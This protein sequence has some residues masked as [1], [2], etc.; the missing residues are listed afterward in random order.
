[1][2]S[3]CVACGVFQVLS[4]TR[5]LMQGLSFLHAAGLVHA[6]LKPDNIVISADARTQIGRA[7][8]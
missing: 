1:M 5:Q 4:F 8:V 7:H 6:D 2:S 3:V